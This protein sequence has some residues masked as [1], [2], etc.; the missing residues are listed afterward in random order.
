MRKLFII[1]I[2]KFLQY[3]VF[4][5]SISR[6]ISESF[7]IAHMRKRPENKRQI[8]G[9]ELFGKFLSSF[10]DSPKNSIE[11]SGFEKIHCLSQTGKSV[12]VKVSYRIDNVFFIHSQQF[13]NVL[14]FVLS[15]SAEI[16]RCVCSPEINC[17]N[18][19]VISFHWILNSVEKLF[20]PF[21]KLLL[22][23]LVENSWLLL[24]SSLRNELEFSQ[25]G[26]FAKFWF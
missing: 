21:N 23:F 9:R 18:K 25:S 1:E 24:S 26:L 13:F 7:L 22:D 2:V 17:I 5:Q 10:L 11:I 14:K 16:L 6:S 15:K 19:L 12:L 8:I 20:F 4:Q 3:S